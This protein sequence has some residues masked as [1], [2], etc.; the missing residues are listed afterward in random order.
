LKPAPAPT[1]AKARKKAVASVEEAARKKAKKAAAGKSKDPPPPPA[2]PHP[3]LP[4]PALPPPPS[5]PP[6]L[7]KFD[8]GV[9]LEDVGMEHYYLAVEQFPQQLKRAYSHWQLS[10]GAQITAIVDE[11][12]KFL[13]VF[14]VAFLFWHV[15][16]YSTATCEFALYMRIRI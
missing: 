11:P 16:L 9:A 6:I 8:W 1:Q 3:A 5:L 15:N 10:P 2:L 13:H 14:C 7:P 4:P 12:G